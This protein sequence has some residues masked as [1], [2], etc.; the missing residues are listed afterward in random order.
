[1]VCGDTSALVFGMVDAVEHQLTGK[2]SFARCCE[3]LAGDCP[4]VPARSPTDITMDQAAL[5]S[6]TSPV[7]KHAEQFKGKIDFVGGRQLG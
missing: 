7:E 1:M 4:T 5:Q 2:R 6:Q 3:M